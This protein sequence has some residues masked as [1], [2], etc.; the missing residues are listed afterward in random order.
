MLVSRVAEWLPRPDGQARMAMNKNCALP[1]MR[2]PSV[3][4]PYLPP[5]LGGGVG[6]ACEAHAL[7]TESCVQARHP[8]GRSAL[9]LK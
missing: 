4:R 1:P 5:H 3:R 7:A 9:S 8:S 6:L 2:S